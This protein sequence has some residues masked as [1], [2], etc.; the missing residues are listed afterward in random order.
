MKIYDAFRPFWVVFPK[1]TIS[2]SMNQGAEEAYVVLE[3]LPFWKGLTDA[4]KTAYLDHWQAPPEWRQEI[5][6]RF[7]WDPAEMER[8]AAEAEEWAATH[9]TYRRDKPWWQFWRRRR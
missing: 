1:L 9:M 3:W 5:I 7:E 2:D 4:E 8:D 6:E